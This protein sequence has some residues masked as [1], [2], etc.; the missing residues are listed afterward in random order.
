MAE[1]LST[2]DVLGAFWM[3][4]KLTVLSAL[5]ALI[6]GTLVAVMR[7][8]PVP[9]LRGMGTAYVNVVR[10]TP[11]TL[12]I[13]FCR[14]GLFVNLGIQVADPMSPTSIADTN[15][16]LGII[17][18]SFYTASFVCEALRSG[19]NTVPVGQ[20]EAA[21]SIGL[22]FV[23][24]LSHVV[25]PQAF[26]AAITPLTNVLIA[27]TKN[28]TVVSV[29]GVA[30]TAYLMSSMIENRS[31]QLYL[32]FAIFAI[33]FVILTLPLGVGLTSLSRRWAV[34]R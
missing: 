34:K 31:D 25:L 13:V 12:V 8:S 4:I 20:A 19:V 6:I 2:F 23:Q 17:G 22:G 24:T 29:I 21:R 7:L 3:T 16:R 32:I 28:T 11:L 15:F 10:N 33:G 1:L 14:L 27:L 9:L 26:R 5:G 18:L 30:E